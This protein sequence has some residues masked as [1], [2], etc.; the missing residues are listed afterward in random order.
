MKNSRRFL[1]IIILILIPFFVS[2]S[3]NNKSDDE[4]DKYGDYNF[5]SSAFENFY[6]VYTK[7]KQVRRIYFDTEGYNYYGDF[8]I[9]IDDT[10]IFDMAD[11]DYFLP[12]TDNLCI[13]VDINP[14]D[15]NIINVEIGN[16]FIKTLSTDIMDYDN[17]NY[18]NFNRNPGL[19]K[20]IWGFD[21]NEVE[22]SN[23][24]TL[25]KGKSKVITKGPNGILN[26]ENQNVEMIDYLR[27]NEVDGISN[28]VTT[29]NVSE[30]SVISQD[31]ITYN[32]TGTWIDVC[33]S[34]TKNHIDSNA[35]L[36]DT[37]TWDQFIIYNIFDSWNLGPESKIYI[38]YDYNAR[39]EVEDSRYVGTYDGM[40]V[41]ECAIGYS[42]SVRIKLT[43]SYNSSSGDII[44][45][46]R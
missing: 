9:L 4:L 5:M 31:D 32:P 44:V 15:D 23:D 8:K 41:I 11:Y 7:D 34:I 29:F 20:Q 14:E 19:T 17:E 16:N 37:Y 25:V 24:F 3:N 28:M 46:K 36:S 6:T 13:P 35:I 26:I 38:E 40:T 42:R 33:V 1:M 22:L 12:A 10:V 21:T 18:V 27:L 43:P 2:C 45:Y 30:D 39:I